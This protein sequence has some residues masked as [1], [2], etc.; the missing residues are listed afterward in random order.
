MYS[1]VRRFLA[2]ECRVVTNCI[3]LTIAKC[4]RF[5]KFSLIVSTKCDGSILMST[6]MYKTLM[7]LV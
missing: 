6:K 3:V 4:V 1:S 2:T 7:L 5:R